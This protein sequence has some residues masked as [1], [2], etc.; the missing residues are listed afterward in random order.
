MRTPLKQRVREIADQ[1]NRE[2]VFYAYLAEDY[3]GIGQQV[4]VALARSSTSSGLMAR[5][6]SGDFGTGQRIPAGTRVSVFSYRGRI[7][8]LSLGAK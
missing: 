6:A 1:T 5:V 3:D 2:H 8:I 7:E 4:K